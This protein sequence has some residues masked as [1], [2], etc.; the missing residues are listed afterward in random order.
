MEAPTAVF[1]R[2]TRPNYYG[3]QQ[4]FGKEYR[5]VRTEFV[6][7]KS[8]EPIPDSRYPAYA[9]MAEDARLIT[10]YRPHCY[11]NTP[12]GTQ[13]STKQWMIHHAGSLMDLSRQR[14]SEWTGASLPMAN[15]VPPPA[16][17]AHSTPFTNELQNSGA[18]FGI[19]TERSDA[20]APALFGT[21]RI[22]PTR[23]E[24]MNN[25]KRIGLTVKYEGG[26]NSLRG[27]NSVGKY[28][29]DG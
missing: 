11:Q 24:L 7:P 6:P 25:K 23:D 5:N 12:A 29:I 18:P 26:R 28:L 4:V 27:S 14:Q 21:F 13:F 19:G 8:T 15:T 10:D 9:G 17:I 1:N 2:I 16:I 3:Q 20:K 22:P